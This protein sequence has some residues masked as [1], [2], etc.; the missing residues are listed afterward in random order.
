M[1]P[2]EMIQNLYKT[3]ELTDVCYRL[4]YSYYKAIF[5]SLKEDEITKKIYDEYLTRQETKWNSAKI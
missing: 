3:I 1:K 5:P 4:K 2:E